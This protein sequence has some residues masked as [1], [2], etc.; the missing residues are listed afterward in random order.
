MKG[1]PGKVPWEGQNQND[2][3]LLVC[4]VALDGAGKAGFRGS[5]VKM[6]GFPGKV[7]REGQNQ[8]ERF[9]LVCGVALDGAGKA[10]F[11]W[12]RVK[13]KGFPGKGSTGRPESE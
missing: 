5:R 7:P 9:L 1:F 2:K 10:G 4:R 8:N 3:F 13:M 6:K 12:S 11:L